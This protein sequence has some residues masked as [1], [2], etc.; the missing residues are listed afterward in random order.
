MSFELALLYVIIA[1]LVSVQC[2][3]I[4]KHLGYLLGPLWRAARCQPLL[5]AWAGLIK[6]LTLPFGRRARD[7]EW[8]WIG[9]MYRLLSAFVKENSNLYLW[10]A[11][12]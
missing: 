4:L 12:L 5:F 8:S 10:P 7:S 3:A 2:P 9:A 1:G 11:V 6:K